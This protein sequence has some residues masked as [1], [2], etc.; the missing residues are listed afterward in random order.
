MYVQNVELVNFKTIKDF[1][2]SFNGGVYFIKGENE[3]GKTTLI[4][5]IVT[6]LTGDRS[7]NLLTTGAEKGYAKITVGDE[8]KPSYEVELRFTQANPRGT[9][10]ITQAG[11]PL[12][13]ENKTVL[14]QIMNYQDF[15]ANEFVR[16]SETAE[17]RRKQIALV[18]SLLPPEINTRIVEIE[19]E[20]ATTKTLLTSINSEVKVYENFIKSSSVT[21]DEVNIYKEPV[22]TRELID[23]KTRAAQINEKRTTTQKEIETAKTD[24]DKIPT[25]ATEIKSKFEK[26]IQE[27]DQDAD[28]LKNEFDL[29]IKR[30]Q[31]RRQSLETD[32]NKEYST[33]DQE[34]EQIAETLKTKEIWLNE[35]PE[36]KLDLIQA[37]IDKAEVHNKMNTKVIE[38][39]KN[40]EQF[41][42]KM[43]EKKGKE[44]HVNALLEEKEKLILS[45]SLPI[46][47][48]SFNE[49]GLTLNNIPF[50]EGE[51]STS[52]EMEVAAKLIIA[53][54]PTTKVFK[55]AQGES[56]G[57]K[58]LDAIVDFALKNG[59]QGFIENVVRGLDELV[60]E[61]YTEREGTIQYD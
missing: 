8:G 33:L 51:I 3:V 47:G 59:Y 1:K 44:S 40:V 18:K 56:L 37:E 9:L 48:L 52:Q 28:R 54:N 57:A 15:D 49:D 35:N 39:N 36:Q 6:L 60:V 50:K 14:Q 31:E 46:E 22:D 16:W 21:T 19:T 11:S 7:D 13:S 4:S 23:K 27:L 42:V 5:A 53:K 25:K 26:S 38:H 17:G 30:L 34:R 29:A 2:Q 24:L 61:E 43:E 10:T 55:I 58:R 41:N 45:S 12:K 20:V 32:I